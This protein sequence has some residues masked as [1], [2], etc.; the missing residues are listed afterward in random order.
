MKIHY[1]ARWARDGKSVAN[2]GLCAASLAGAKRQ[3]NQI[4]RKLGVTNT[5]RTITQSSTVVECIQTGV[6]PE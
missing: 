2:V 4:A 6:S 5:P 3:A 1:T